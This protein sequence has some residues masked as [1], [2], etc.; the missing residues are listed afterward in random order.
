MLIPHALLP[1]VALAYAAGIIQDEQ[2]EQTLTYLLIR[3]IPRWA[4]YAVKLLATLTT[5][6]ILTTVFTA[7][8]FV[9]I[10]VG[11]QSPL[12]EVS[13]RCL[14]AIAM[15]DLAVI[16]Y[17]CLFGLFSLMTDRALVLGIVYSVIFEGF[18]ANMPFG[19][20]LITII[21]YCRSIAYQ[22]ME[23][24]VTAR[25][26]TEDLA[27]TAWK[28]NPKLMAEM[29]S[30]QTCVTVLVVA[31]LVFAGIGSIMFARREFHV[32]TPEGN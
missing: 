31:S 24:K 10:Y 27:A 7:L 20:R 13:V 19:I 15:H 2:E 3:P 22:W 23:F 14:K 1:I 4:I 5:T 16:A 9:A 29:T 30:I 8:T 6:V 11:S 28:F 32:K 12:G 18:I 26:H 21:Y 17:C 25:G